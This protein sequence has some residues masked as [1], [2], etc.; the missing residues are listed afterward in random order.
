M[1]T[2]SLSPA[3]TMDIFYK[4]AAGTLPTFLNV[5]Y[6]ITSTR[7]NRYLIF[8][9]HYDSLNNQENFSFFTIYMPLFKNMAMA[10]I[11][12]GQLSGL[13]FSSVVVPDMT[14]Q[15]IYIFPII[16]PYRNDLN[17][18]LCQNNQNLVPTQLSFYALFDPSTYDV[19]VGQLAPTSTEKVGSRACLIGKTDNTVALKVME[20]NKQDLFLLPMLL[21]NA[22]LCYIVFEAES[23]LVNFFNGLK[24][25]VTFQEIPA[26]VW[27][28][29]LSCLVGFYKEPA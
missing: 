13:E 14:D 5:F 9:E 25:E 15:S 28:E 8:Q 6:E 3:P 11:S 18:G 4:P 10:K 23:T 26:V 12:K 27:S 16:Y 22:S 19:N 29:P 20:P 17:H 1:A 7:G 2:L 24:N 21:P